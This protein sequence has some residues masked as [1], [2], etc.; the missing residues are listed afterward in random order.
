MKASRKTIKPATQPTER[1]KLTSQQALM[2]REATVHV[3]AANE[4]QNLLLTTVLAAAGIDKAD[5]RGGNLDGP[6]P[7]IE[8]VRVP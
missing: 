3:Q 1:I 8:V 2:L 6:E 7:H 4:R 5:V